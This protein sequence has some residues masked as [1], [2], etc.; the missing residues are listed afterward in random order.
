MILIVTSLQ[1]GAN[2]TNTYYDY[3]SGVDNLKT[4]GDRTLVD[5]E[6]TPEGIFN[7]SIACYA[8]AAFLFAPQI[9]GNA[10]IAVFMIGSSLAIFYTAK[11][12][13]LKYVAMGDIVILAAFGP[14]T[15][16]FVSLMLT[17]KL[18]PEILPYCIP[19]ALMTEA[20]L[21][22]NN[23]RDIKSDRVAGI[24]TLPTLLGFEASF[25]I[26]CVLHLVSY[27]ITVVIAIYY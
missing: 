25:Q 9:E 7:L 2:L 14:I 23:S 13:G 21:H 4:V 17:G 27:V 15:Q 8:F 20:I 1:A 10:I 24:T 18:Q 6:C 12:L 5:K 26:Y 22:A 11:P 3:A 16:Q 19:I